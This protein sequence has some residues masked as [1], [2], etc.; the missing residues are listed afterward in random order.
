VLT[1]NLYPLVELKL[2]VF[3]L[4][5]HVD[6]RIGAFG[7]DGVERTELPPHAWARAEQHTG[8][9]FSGAD[10]VLADLTDTHAVVAAVVGPSPPADD[11]RAEGQMA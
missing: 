8:H 5:D 7:G 4:A 11:P 9:R 6:L 3:G 10:A 1:G 2:D